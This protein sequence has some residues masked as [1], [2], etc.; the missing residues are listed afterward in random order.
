MLYYAHH[1]KKVTEEIKVHTEADHLNGEL[2]ITLK[3]YTMI[4]ICNTYIK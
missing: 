2:M 3:N 4:K 1:E